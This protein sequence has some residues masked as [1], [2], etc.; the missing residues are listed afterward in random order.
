MP[1]NFDKWFTLAWTFLEDRQQILITANERSPND[2][3]KQKYTWYQY[4][5]H[6]SQYNLTNN[7]LF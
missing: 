5:V 2:F 7:L 4:H 6:V 3:Q 1:V